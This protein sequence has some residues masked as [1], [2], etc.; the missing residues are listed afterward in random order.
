MLASVSRL[1]V[2]LVA[3]GDG[4]LVLERVYTR[5]RMRETKLFSRI[6]MKI[7]LH[8]LLNIFISNLEGPGEALWDITVSRTCFQNIDAS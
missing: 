3:I 1:C 8:A 5:E 7:I 6:I 4:L 2:Q